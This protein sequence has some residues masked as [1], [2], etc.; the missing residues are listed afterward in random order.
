MDF[1]D[2]INL[3][4]VELFYLYVDGYFSILMIHCL[5]I[6]LNYCSSLV[7]FC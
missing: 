5:M 1:L 6:P 3:D 2:V 7:M 4:D